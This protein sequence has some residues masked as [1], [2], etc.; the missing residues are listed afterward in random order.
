[1]T[2]NRELEKK[3]EEDRQKIVRSRVWAKKNSNSLK[4]NKKA[5]SILNREMLA[6]HKKRSYVRAFV[7]SKLIVFF[8]FE[9][10]EF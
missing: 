2:E 7:R 9:A 5:S 1:M 8:F 3:E 6:S 10:S 4:K